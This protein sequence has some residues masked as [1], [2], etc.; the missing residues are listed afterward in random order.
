[1]P[2][3]AEAIRQ[4]RNPETVYEQRIQE[5]LRE[6]ESIKR[7]A[8]N[9]VQSYI[10]QLKKDAIFG[11]LTPAKELA[12]ATAKE[13]IGSFKNEVTGQMQMI[14]SSVEEK[15]KEIFARIDTYI[16]K[17]KE[18]CAKDI[19]NVRSKMLDDLSSEKKTNK[20]IYDT[21]FSD[22][23]KTLQELRQKTEK[24]LYEIAQNV[25]EMRG[26]IGQQGE[27]GKDGKD[28]SPDDAKTIA[29]KLN[30]TE[31]TLQMKVI[32]GLAEKLESLK[33]MIHTN[34]GG[35]GGGMGNIYHKTFSC[36][37]AT[38]VFALDYSVAAGGSAIWVYYQGQ[39][40]F[41]GTHY[42]VNRGIITTTFTPES[43]TNIDVTYVRGS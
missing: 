43:G 28:G 5:I 27:R 35:R 34:S 36:D 41:K 29:A 26:P 6:L 16:Q 42:N 38:T 1:M 10:E 31:N 19:L 8:K 14:I 3:L 17:T 39:F 15:E 32:Y 7:E 13:E 37:G 4:R 20:I 23:Q 18:D 24:N 22:T 9:D 25:R 40:L 2:T 21:L 12:S 11:N 33:K 30:D